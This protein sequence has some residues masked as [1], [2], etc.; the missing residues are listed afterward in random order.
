MPPAAFEPAVKAS[1]LPKI[2]ALYQAATGIGV[3]T[4][5]RGVEV[6]QVTYFGTFSF[7]PAI[8]E[9]CILL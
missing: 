8:I 7:L 3:M 2:Y 5:L 4:F 1:V 6:Q 9:S